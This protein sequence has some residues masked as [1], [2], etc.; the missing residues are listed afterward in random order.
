[1]YFEIRSG[2]V[3]VQG[4]YK[5]DGGWIRS[6][7]EVDSK[8]TRGFNEMFCNIF[9]LFYRYL[10]NSTTAPDLNARSPLKPI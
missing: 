10:I 9:L 2:K 1:M 7:L 5:V 8:W 4:G 3:D 6:G